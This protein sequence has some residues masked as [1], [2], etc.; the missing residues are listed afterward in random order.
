MFVKCAPSFAHEYLG[1]PLGIPCLHE[2]V[3]VFILHV[4]CLVEA[5]NAIALQIPIYTV[6]RAL[7]A[8]IRDVEIFGLRDTFS[9]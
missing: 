4:D 3:V 2:F 5:E 9:R 6:W 7:S 8:R 1:E